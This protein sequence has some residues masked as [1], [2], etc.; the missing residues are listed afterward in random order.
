MRR[1][2]LLVWLG[3]FLNCTTAI[4]AQLFSDFDFQ[5]AIETMEGGCTTALG[6]RS[7]QSMIALGRRIQAME[8]LGDLEFSMLS[9]ASVQR[10][11]EAL[12]KVQKSDPQGAARDCAIIELAKLRDR[13][14]ARKGIIPERQVV[15]LIL[16]LISPSEEDIDT[17]GR[18]ATDKHEELDYRIRAAAALATSIFHRL[19]KPISSDAEMNLIEKLFTYLALS[20]YALHTEASNTTDERKKTTIRKFLTRVDSDY[21]SPACK[22]VI[23]LIK[24]DPNPESRMRALQVIIQHANML[25]VEADPVVETI[26]RIYEDLPK[27]KSDEVQMLVDAL[28]AIKGIRF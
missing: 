19:E 4:S 24:N 7:D 26:L 9:M 23:E 25:V 22:L 10:M 16:G 20:Y 17:L 27:V 3:V 12:R 8:Y 13:A 28:C 15:T 6:G 2:I 11:V 21:R 5:T 18:I 1:V 14:K